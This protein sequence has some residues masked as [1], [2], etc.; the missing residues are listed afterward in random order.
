MPFALE[1]NYTYQIP[2]ELLPAITHGTRVEVPFRNKTYTGIVAKLHDKKPEGYAVKPILSLP[3]HLQVV[4]KIQ[5]DFWQWM[6][7][8]YMCSMG[9]VMNAAL[10]GPYKLSSETILV[11]DDKSRIDTLSLTDKEHFVADA[12]TSKKE[13][14]LREIQ[15]ILRQRSVQPVIKSLIE[16]GIALVKEEMKEGYKPRVEK[17]ITLHQQYTEEKSLQKLFDTLEKSEKNSKQLNALMIYY[18]EM[19]GAGRMRKTTLMR[20]AGVS[21]A[22]LKTMVKNK[23][24]IEFNEEVSRLLGGINADAQKLDLSPSQSMAVKNIEKQF[25]ER[26]VV[27]LHGITGSGKTEIYIELIKKFA[28]EGKQVLYL[29]PEI[30][31]TAQIINRLKKH[32]GEFVG[33]YHSKF[34]QNERIEIWQKILNKQ[35]KI[36]LGARSA[37]FLPFQQLGLVIIDEEHDYSYKQQDPNPRYNA[38]DSA[39][40]LAHLHEAKTLLG[41]ATPAIESY[42]NTQTKKYGLVNLNTRYADVSLPEIEVI[43]LQETFKKHKSNQQFVSEELI[44]S[45]NGSLQKNEQVIIF[46]NRR[47]FAPYIVCESCGWVPNCVNCDVKLVY[48]KYADELRCHYCGYKHKTFPACPACNSTRILIQGTGTE[49]IE[50]EL[51]L[52]FPEK[53]VARLDLD[54]VRAKHGHEKILS[55]FEEGVI[56]IL[57]GTQMITKGLDFDNVNLVGIINADQIW[58]FA[59]F[60]ANERAF[61]MIT[62]VSG[63]AGRKSK[64]GKVLIQALQTKHPVLQYVAENNY[65]LMFENELIQRQNFL[66]P[67]FVRIIQVIVKHKDMELA[68]NAANYLVAELRKKLS[69]NVLGP[70]IPA[71]SR[72]KNKFHFEILVKL[73]VDAGRILGAKKFMKQVLLKLP[74]H[75]D[76]KS[77]EVVIDVDPL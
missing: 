69:K 4:H 41:T 36:V 29:L 63:R 28:L 14:S 51:Q 34:N 42:Y 12:L 64:K 8:Y 22:V 20:K 30:A 46:Q 35:Y 19:Q 17:Y 33:I 57:V 11:L 47:G 65:Q 71:I 45:I 24:F 67:P 54:A 43:P 55:E 59:D 18:Q 2:E 7:E 74:Q 48:H 73:P 23:I 27:L 25:T 58:N 6:A 38:R 37:L 53:K 56:D 21:A 66:Y 16:K 13:L 75:A 77:A 68:G 10:P 60:R 32:F 50:D 72:I 44:S 3:D 76:L 31:L 70:T 15:K 62:Q 40:Y 61:Q 39:I 26:N 1:K 52:L 9:D 49:K 5:L